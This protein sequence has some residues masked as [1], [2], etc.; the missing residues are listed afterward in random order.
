MGGH[1]ELTRGNVARP[2][3][4]AEAGHSDNLGYKVS[5]QDRENPHGGGKSE[6]SLGKEGKRARSRPVGCTTTLLYQGLY[7]PLNAINIK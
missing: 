2:T 6:R 4:K 3:G 1:L 7:C 5:G